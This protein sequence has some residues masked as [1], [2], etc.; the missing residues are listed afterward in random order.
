[1][2][3]GLPDVK[4]G[5]NDL[6][7]EEPQLVTQADELQP[8]MAFF[9]QSSSS[10]S[11]VTSEFMTT[12]KPSEVLNQLQNLNKSHFFGKFKIETGPKSIKMESDQ[13]RVKVILV[14]TIGHM[15]IQF[16][17][18]HGFQRDFN[19][20]MQTVA[21]SLPILEPIYNST[22]LFKDFSSI[23]EHKLSS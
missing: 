10:K 23:S 21:N 2:L 20:F 7:P 3:H 22:P 13:L 15:N 18:R 11:I 1:M 9:N 6:N 17:K 19:D 4:V 5:Y 14:G 12:S 8:N 16:I